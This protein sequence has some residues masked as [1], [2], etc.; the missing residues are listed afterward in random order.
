MNIMNGTHRLTTYSNDTI[1]TFQHLLRIDGIKSETEARYPR[2]RVINATPCAHQETALKSIYNEPMLI[3]L[4]V[5][6][7][8]T[9][10]LPKL[11]NGGIHSVR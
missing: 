4:L 2:L 6:N 3:D 8:S 11:R 1:S 9:Q 10:S 5:W 7:C